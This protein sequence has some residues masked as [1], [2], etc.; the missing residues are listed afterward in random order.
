MYLFTNPNLGSGVT[1]GS[2]NHY[3]SGDDYEYDMNMFDNLGVGV[4]ANNSN[5]ICRYSAF[6]YMNNLGATVGNYTGAGIYSQRDASGAATDGHYDL[7]VFGTDYTY[8]NS[9]YNC[10]TG[11]SANDIYNVFGE[12]NRYYSTNDY[13]VPS[14]IYG[15]YGYDITSSE[16]LLNQV[17]YNQFYNLYCGVNISGMAATSPAG[18]VPG[19]SNVDTNLINANIGGTDGGSY[20]E[21]TYLG[22]SVSNDPSYDGLVPGG[23]SIYVDGNMINWAYNGIY[24]NGDPGDGNYVVI[25]NNQVNIAT[26][27]ATGYRVEEQ[28]GITHV[29]SYAGYVYNNNITGDADAPL[30]PSATYT[31]PIVEA[32]HTGMVGSPLFLQG[33]YTE[34]NNEQTINTGFYFGGIN[35]Y[36][37][38]V[39]NNMTNNY[40]GYVLDGEIGPQVNTSGLAIL[41]NNAWLGTTWAGPPYQTYVTAGS[42]DATLSPLAVSSTSATFNPVYNQAESP[43]LPYLTL[44]SSIFEYSVDPSIAYNFTCTPTPINYFY[45]SERVMIDNYTA[46]KMLKLTG[47][48]NLDWIMQESLFTALNTN[49]NALIEDQELT[50]F[51]QKAQNSR[52]HYLDSLRQLI[53][54]GK[55][56]EARKLLSL[57][58]NYLQ[59]Y[60]STD[61]I[62]DNGTIPDAMVQRYK[63]FYSLQIAYHSHSMNLADSNE[64]VAISNLCPYTDGKVVYEA[65][66]LYNQ[67]FHKIRM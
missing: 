29:N 8:D 57:P 36:L 38:W 34:C 10:P 23:C 30:S 9:F 67:V 59:H 52:F 25:Q 45:G 7:S 24:V 2:G 31:V 42:A 35:Y 47:N 53:V 48:I 27:P 13:T 3:S 22:I 61:S 11:V 12:Y 44:Y 55:Y 58:L 21:Y 40:Y 51:Y 4:Y 63:D 15:M 28:A 18:Y 54:K 16:W 60:E 41:S 1:L 6:M 17:S 64:L 37:F 43:N 65:R 14:T 33:E 5:V 62:V 46:Y 49:K 39:D 50:N 56:T 26:E 32:F 20:N 66:A 19:Q